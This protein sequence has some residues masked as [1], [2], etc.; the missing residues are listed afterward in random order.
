VFHP[1]KLAIEYYGLGAG[2]SH[3]R[4]WKSGDEEWWVVLV[5]PGGALACWPGETFVSL[6]HQDLRYYRV[7]VF[8]SV[9]VRTIPTIIVT[10]LFMCGS[11]V[12]A[13]PLLL[14]FHRG[15]QLKVDESES[16]RVDA[17]SR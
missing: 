5:P 17:Y 15:L 14:P 10:N 8:V 2:L 13:T 1:D 4:T 7:F 3:E 16:E 11:Y 9:R 12:G 6:A